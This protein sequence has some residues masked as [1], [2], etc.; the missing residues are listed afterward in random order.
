VVVAAVMFNGTQYLIAGIARDKPAYERERSALRAAINSFRA[1]TPAERKAAR[2]YRL[3]LVTAQPGMT[4]VSL[5]WQ[6]PLGADAESQ[7]RLMNDLYPNGEPM[8]GQLLKIVQ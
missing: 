8:P 6:S 1:I 5:A 2:P 7:L 4:V 3:Q